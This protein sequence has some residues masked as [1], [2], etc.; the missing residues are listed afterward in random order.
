MPRGDPKVQC[1][2]R[3]PSWV[4]RELERMAEEGG[5]TSASAVAGAIIEEVIRDDLAAHKRRAPE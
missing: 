5:H 2:M 1:N 4:R 3:I